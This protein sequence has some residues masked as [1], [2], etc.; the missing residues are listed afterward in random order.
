MQNE[1][2]I[3]HIN[4]HSKETGADHGTVARRAPI[5][6]I[7]LFLFLRQLGMKIIAGPTCVSD[8]L[9]KMKSTFDG[10]PSHTIPFSSWCSLM[11][12][13]TSMAL[14]VFR[15]QM[16]NCKLVRWS[17]SPLSRTTRGALFRFNYSFN[18]AENSFAI[19]ADT[20]AMG[21]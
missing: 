4:S 17:S 16:L 1:I 21:N 13:T 15:L 18:L 6:E 20:I 19:V 5:F 9:L 11:N 14:L 12:P 3:R 10:H 2:H 7:F 8:N